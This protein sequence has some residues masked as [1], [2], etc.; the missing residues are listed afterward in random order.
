MHNWSLR[1]QPPT[2][3]QCLA[4]ILAR[5]RSG[6]NL[7]EVAFKEGHIT[8]CQLWRIDQGQN[9]H[10]YT[11]VSLQED[12]AYESPH[13]QDNQVEEEAEEGAEVEEQQ[14][15]PMLLP[16]RIHS[17]TPRSE[18]SSRGSSS[19]RLRESLE[20]CCGTLIETMFQLPLSPDKE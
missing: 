12:A 15:L 5:I 16:L 4:A 11:E 13:Y 3:R 10:L 18:H 17:A 20:E 14:P 7:D 9:P 6:I 19:E 1:E 8:Y 2:P